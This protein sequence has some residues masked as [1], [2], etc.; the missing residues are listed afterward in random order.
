MG[1]I[2]SGIVDGIVSALFGWLSGIMEKRGLVNQGKAQEASLDN[3][4][5]AKAETAMAQASQ[6]APHSETETEAALTK[7]AF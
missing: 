2:I 4:A 3:V 1:T 6:D 7:G 5:T